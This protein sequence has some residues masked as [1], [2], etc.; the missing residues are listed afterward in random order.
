MSGLTPPPEGSSCLHLSS[1]L[2]RPLVRPPWD[3][4]REREVLPAP[5]Q[6]PRQ[7]P[8]I[9][10]VGIL[11]YI[12]HAIP[13]HHIPRRHKNREIPTTHF[14][15]FKYSQGNCMRNCGNPQGGLVAATVSR[16]QAV[17]PTASA[18]HAGGHPPHTDTSRHP[19]PENAPPGNTTGAGSVGFSPPAAR[20]CSPGQHDRC[21]Q[22]RLLA[23]RRPRMLPRATT[24]EPREPRHD[25]TRV[26]RHRQ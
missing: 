22:R 9:V 20:E 17:R 18:P 5:R 21:G 23:A 12:S 6:A 14:Q 19:P 13:R 16:S 8:L 26:R 1:L 3:T 24:L 11:P 7:A 2:V 4:Y 15:S 10:T 25:A